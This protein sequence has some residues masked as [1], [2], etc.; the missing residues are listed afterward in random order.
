MGVRTRRPSRPKP[1]HSLTD[2]LTESGFPS[3]IGTPSTTVLVLLL[4]HAGLCAVLLGGR[5]SGTVPA[6][7]AESQAQLVRGAG[8]SVGAAA[9]QGIADLRAATAVPAATPDDLVARLMQNGKW[10]GAAVLDAGTRALVA[11]RG[12]PVAVQPP[13]RPGTG[14]TVTPVVGADGTLRVVVA[15]DAARR[16]AARRR[17]RQQAPR[18]LARR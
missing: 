12:E 7:I 6:A 15:E 1:G 16:Q 5:E 2:Q 14:T 11:S 13:P 8:S 4:L 18:R 3:G 10:R 9:S 17:A